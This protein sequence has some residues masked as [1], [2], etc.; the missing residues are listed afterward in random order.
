MDSPAAPSRSSKHGLWLPL[1]FGTALLLSTVGIGFNL[2]PTDTSIGIWIMVFSVGLALV[3]NTCRR[4]LVLL[5]SQPYKRSSLWIALASQGVILGFTAY[6][7]GVTYNEWEGKTPL[8]LLEILR[9]QSVR[10]D[11][12]RQWMW[13]MGL[14]YWIPM[15]LLLSNALLFSVK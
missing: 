5:Y 13:D 1:W 3:A 9:A 2:V 6:F 11:G 15:G 12:L 7:A 8:T 4:A 10:H 14:L